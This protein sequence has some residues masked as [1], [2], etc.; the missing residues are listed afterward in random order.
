M[1]VRTAERRRHVR[2]AASYGAV[3]HNGRRRVLARG[4]TVNISENGVFVVVRGRPRLAEV[5]EVFA[6]LVIPADPVVGTTREVQYRCRVVRTVD[7][8][9]MTGVGLELIEKLG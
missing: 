1:T 7:L 8:A 6:D 3:L 5:G 9:D 4:R 2:V